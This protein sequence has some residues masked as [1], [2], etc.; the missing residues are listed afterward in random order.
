[1]KKRLIR[2]APLLLLVAVVTLSVVV[3]AQANLHDV[4][5][6]IGRLLDVNDPRVVVGGLYQVKENGH[7]R[8][9]PPL[10]RPTDQVRGKYFEEDSGPVRIF[11]VLGQTIPIIGRVSTWVLA[12]IDPTIFASGQTE[13]EVEGHT[14]VIDPIAHVRFIE[15]SRI[16]A[17]IDEVYGANSACETEVKSLYLNGRCVVIVHQT[18]SA[19]GVMLGYGYNNRC[20]NADLGDDPASY[21]GLPDRAPKPRR[22]L[23]ENISDFKDYVGLIDIDLRDGPE[24]AA[25]L[26]EGR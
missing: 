19:D 26:A 10:C 22:R 5:I 3:V 18:S 7:L 12:P 21:E 17:Y 6:R 15:L 25:S 8:S 13:L 16:P 23:A 1:M 14:L 20:L 11:N 24:A 2:I 9:G 4:R